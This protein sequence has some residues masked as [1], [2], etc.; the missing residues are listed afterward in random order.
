MAGGAAINVFKFNTGGLPKETLNFKLWFAVFA[1]G[2]MGAARGVD[3]GLITG[4]FNSHAFKRSVGIDDLDKDDLASVKGT[5][6]S[7]VQLGSVAGALLAFIVCDRIGRVWATRQLCVL[8]ILGIAIFIGN[9]GNMA[10]VYAGRFIA[11]LGIGQTC[12]VGPIYLSEISPAPIRG[13]CTCMFTGAVYLGIMIAYFANWGTQIHMADTFNRWAVPTSLHLM[14]AGII[15]FLTFFQ[16]ESPRFYIKQGKREKALEV[17]CKLRGLPAHHPYVLNE[18]SEMDVAFQEEMEAT[19]GMGWKGLFKEILG[20]KRNA[21]R[22][23]LTNLAQN[24][25]CWSGGSAITVYAPDLFTLVGIT[26]QEQSLFSTV[27]FGVVKFVA[28]IICALFL[29]DMAGR[30]RAL[31][32]GIVIQTVA[33]FY[34]AIFLNLVPIAG[35]PDFVPSETQN[36]ASTAAIAFIY[37]SGV[38][39]ALGWNSGQYLLSS[40][41]FPLRIRGICS[42]ITMAMHFICQYAVNRVLPEMLL[43]D[44]GLGPHGTFYFFGVI[45]ILGGVWVWLFVPEAAGR[46]LETI[47]KMFDLP[48]YKIGLYGRKFAE[49]YDREQ[50]EIYRD[51]KRDAGIVVSHNE[52]A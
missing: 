20:I 24:M 11:G 30:K 35:N 3:E 14:F 22:L 38:G 45:S 13:L 12:V 48:W 42:S 27:V 44:T 39:W 4:V 17:L 28:A 15:L 26:G 2:L 19:L 9:N 8:W 33:M 7:M 25:A 5:I 34:I 36:R 21:Y 1:F 43:E 23:F 47:D 37:I 51:E 31:I 16:L 10:A 32:I 49:E 52:A 6:S 18:I 29:V 50:E 40:E 41:L 46:S